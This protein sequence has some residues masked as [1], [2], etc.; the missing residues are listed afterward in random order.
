MPIAQIHMLEG[1]P[2]EVKKKL[3]EEVTAA[4]SRCLDAKPESVRV[5][6]YEIPKN[7][8]AVGGV[9]MEERNK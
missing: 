4:I 6:L 2:P 5:L 8:W 9:T 1:R 3:I 7:Q